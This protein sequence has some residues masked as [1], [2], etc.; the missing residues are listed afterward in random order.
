MHVQ[1]LESELPLKMSRTY[2]LV[3]DIGHD[4]KDKIAKNPEFRP[5]WG[6]RETLELFVLLTTDGNSEISP[7]SI[8]VN[9]EKDGVCE[10]QELSF[11]PSRPGETKITFRIFERRTFALLQ[12]WDTTIDVVV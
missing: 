7:S 8:L 10:I 1:I 9:L 3:V 2:H 5:D 4:I 6:D 12:A 11:T